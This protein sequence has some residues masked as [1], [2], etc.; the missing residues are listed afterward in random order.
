MLVTMVPIVVDRSRYRPEVWT[1][2]PGGGNEEAVKA[3]GVEV[4]CLHRKRS[5][6]AAFALRASSTVSPTY[7]SSAPGASF[8]I[9]N[10]PSGAGL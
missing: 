4:N 2:H 9:C 5:F 6:S 7:Q 1:L 10:N 8:P 3:T